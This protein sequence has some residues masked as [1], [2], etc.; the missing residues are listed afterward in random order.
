MP[1]VYVSSAKIS[2][3]ATEVGAERGRREKGPGCGVGAGYEE[4]PLHRGV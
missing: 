4:A 2:E 1:N 3:A